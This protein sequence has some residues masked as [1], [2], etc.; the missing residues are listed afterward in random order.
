M[1]KDFTSRLIRLLAVYDYYYVAGRLIHEGFYG[2]VVEP[3][4]FRS[5][6]DAA[7]HVVSRSPDFA[8]AFRA[9]SS[10]KGAA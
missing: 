1:A 5:A 10:G 7:E 2:T 9:L 4:R 3:Y 8:A 6:F